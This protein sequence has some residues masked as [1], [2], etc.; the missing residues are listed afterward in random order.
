METFERRILFVGGLSP[1]ITEGELE[2]HFSQFCEVNGVKLMKDKKTKLP[3]GYA[4]VY[5]KQEP[6]SLDELLEEPHIVGGRKV[7]VQV[8]SRKCDKQK[9][10]QEQQTRRVFIKNIPLDVTPEEL[11]DSFSA[12]GKVKNAYLINDYYTGR[13]KGQGYLHFEETESVLVA[14]QQRVYIR[15]QLISCLPYVGRHDKAADK[16]LICSKP[17]QSRP[18]TTQIHKKSKQVRVSATWAD[19]SLDGAECSV[20][21]HQWE[22][23]WEISQEQQLWNQPEPNY[24]YEHYLEP[25]QVHH[26][27]S[28][29]SYHPH[30]Q[31]IG[32]GIS[33]TKPS[34]GVHYGTKNPCIPTGRHSSGNFPRKA[35]CDDGHISQ[36]D[37]SSS[38]SAGGGS[39]RYSSKCEEKNLFLRD[40]DTPQ[41]IPRFSSRF[42]LRTFAERYCNGGYQ[43]DINQE[44]IPLHSLIRLLTRLS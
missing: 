2:S 29:K 35:P 38:E 37:T 16:L 14:L 19:R 9:W 31:E 43:N 3:K 8:A 11:E 36:R 10:K 7:D 41:T 32:L 44:Y 18:S 39:P 21:E 6:P 12:F 20:G 34:S 22:G 25:M 4:Y 23:D 27:Q 30:H 26:E 1:A 13:P 24:A 40:A 5:L 33:Q 15:G 42:S 17:S 28:F